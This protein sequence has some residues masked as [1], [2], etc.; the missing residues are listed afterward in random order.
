MV[1]RLGWGGGCCVLV[2]DWE[3]VLGFSAWADGWGRAIA[4]A[5][6]F[7]TGKAYGGSRLGWT[8]GVGRRLLNLVLDWEGVLGFSAWL[9]GWGRGAGC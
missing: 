7:W 3:G 8:A 6:W 5:F 1:G 4:A 2:L 9:D